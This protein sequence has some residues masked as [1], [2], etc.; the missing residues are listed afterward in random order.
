MPRRPRDPGTPQSPAEYFGA[1]LRA[2]REAAGMTRPQLAEKLG[3][4]GQ[5]IGQIE[6][7]TSVPSETFAE[8]LDT[9]FS[10]NGAFHR[11]WGWIKDIGKLQILPPGFPEFV[12]REA[13]ASVIY[14]FAAMVAHGL[15]QTP[16]YAREVLKE[17]R[18][19]EEIEQ[20]VATRLERQAILERDDPP[21]LVAVLDEYAVRRPIG[22]PAIMREQVQHLIEL[23]QRPN[24]A[25]QIVPSSKGSYAGLMGAF[26]ILKF[27]EEPDVVY[28]EGHVDGQLIERTSTVRG[29][30]LGFDRIRGAAIPTDES[31]QLLHAILESL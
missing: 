20:L 25:M 21:Q 17:G 3:Y 14:T 9:F 10:T 31:L 8:D 13:K 23:A 28:L 12:E 29:Y 16:E 7:A 27:D 22:D 6:L 18:T 4:T 30:A 24:I 26:T 11:L 1:E 19:P 2:Y 15:F 5:W